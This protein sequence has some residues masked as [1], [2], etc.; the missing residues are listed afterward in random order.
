MSLKFNGTEITAAT[1]NSTALDRIIIDGTEVW[2]GKV[3]LI[4]DSVINSSLLTQ[5][6]FKYVDAKSFGYVVDSIGSTTSKEI[7]NLVLSSGIDEDNMDWTLCAYEIAQ[8]ITI[9]SEKTKLIVKGNFTGFEYD[10]GS[11]L[12]Y[13]KTKTSYKAQGKTYINT[14]G[15]GL[16]LTI[17]LTEITVGYFRMAFLIN[18]PTVPTVKIQITDM[19]FE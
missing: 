6:E 10:N 7:T 2:S 11:Y 3:Y 19:W 18:E 5:T 13:Y 16:E 8:N 1:F 4:K 17:D 9:P 12:A 15:K 14:G